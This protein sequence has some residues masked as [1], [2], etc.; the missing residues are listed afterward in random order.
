[1]DNKSIP[2]RPS[3]FRSGSLQ[4]PRRPVA[5]ATAAIL[6]CGTLWT[7]AAAGQA[8]S[9][10]LPEIAAL[11]ARIAQDDRR[12]PELSIQLAQQALAQASATPEDRRWLRSR[13]IRDLIRMRRTDEAL[14]QAQA[15]RAE[16][17]DPEGQLHFDVLALDALGDAQ[18][19][20]EVVK[21][22]QG[23]AAQLQPLGN[24]RND[25]A[26]MDVANAWRLAGTAMMRLGQLPES[27]QLLTQAL[28]V[29]DKLPDAVYETS[30]TLSAMA[31]V[32]AKSGNPE[33]A[34]HTVQRAIDLSEAANERSSLSGYQLRKAYLLG[35]L[36][37]TDEQ[38]TALLAARALAQQELM[39]YNLG[40]AA[41]NLADVALQKKDYPAALAYTNEAIPL[42]EQTGDKESLWVAWINKGTALNRLGKPGGIDWIR[43]ALAAFAAAPGMDGTVAEVHGLLA[44]ELAFNHDYQRAY[45]AAM[46]FERLTDGVRK[47]ADHKRIAEANAAYE[48][49][50]RQRQ[51]EGLEQ[52]QR[53]QLRFRWMLALA[54]AAGLAAAV[55]AAVSRYHVKRAYGA[56]RDM[57][58]SDPLTGL[59]NRRHLVSTI[60]ADLG[61]ARRLRNDTRSNPDL[62]FLMIDID[63]FKSVNDVHGHAAGDAVLKQCA[64]V[65]QRQLRE[66]DTL[67]RWGGEEFLVLARQTNV[68]EVHVLAERLR[69]SIAAHSFTLDDGQVLH[70]TCSIGFACYPP[71]DRTGQPTDWQDTVSM[72]DQCLYVAKSSGRDLWVGVIAQAALP[73][74]EGGA[75]QDLRAGVESGAIQL[76]WGEGRE[77]VW[78]ASEPEGVRK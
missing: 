2:D 13:L 32:D 33:Q 7:M 6:L 36:G 26:S 23:F 15:G 19:N 17:R 41:T 54:A 22:Y 74:Q 37:R 47:A 57:A 5:F 51:I 35:L 78:A 42:V 21:R 64:A 70:K 68:Q 20:V 65:L 16:A 49:D 3:G 52:E 55:I 43:K 76:R 71:Q 30:Q 44:E 14:A 18:R 9:G 50:K 56:M 73:G 11:K 58:F 59:R 24:T 45:E 29:F 53:Q 12:R 69:A 27:I 60:E 67:V 72:A 31:L 63:H 25:A 4:Q 38:Q 1:M 39:S 61:L 62:V 46:Q 75:I 34:L 40:V 77:I 48:A 8:A 10:P 28:R 66:S